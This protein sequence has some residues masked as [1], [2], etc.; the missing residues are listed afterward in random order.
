[1]APAKRTLLPPLRDAA[2][3]LPPCAPPSRRLPALSEAPPLE[4]PTPPPLA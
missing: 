4:V 1:M 2:V 3:P